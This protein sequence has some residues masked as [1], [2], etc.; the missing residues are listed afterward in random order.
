ME[1]DDGYVAGGWIESSSLAPRDDTSSIR[2][3]PWHP[4]PAFSSLFSSGDQWQSVED[5]TPASWLPSALSSRG[6]GFSS[7]TSNTSEPS[8]REPWFP[9]K[10]I[11]TQF[12]SATIPS[13][14]TLQA[15][16]PTQPTTPVS[17]TLASHDASRYTLQQHGTV[18]ST[19]HEIASSEHSLPSSAQSSRSSTSRDIRCDICGKEFTGNYSRGN[20]ARH[21]RQLHDP[22]SVMA[23]I[24]ACRVCGQAFRRTD[25]RRKH[26]WNKHNLEGAKPLPRRT[27]K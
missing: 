17:I 11:Q 18:D 13:S 8:D 24:H 5:N 23:E 27:E 1:I 7:C 2:P 6:L 22:T 10:R 4:L 14:A 21:V 12:L 9:G 20:L 25:A 16:Q 3:R 19:S 15:S 26:E